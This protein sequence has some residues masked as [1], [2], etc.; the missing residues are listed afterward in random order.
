VGIGVKK[1]VTYHGMAVNINTD[2]RLFSYIRPCGLDVKMTSVRQILGRDV[3]LTQSKQELIRVFKE[4]F[5]LVG[6]SDGLR[7]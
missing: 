4:R 3:D 5:G 1:W 7:S 6:S 2:L